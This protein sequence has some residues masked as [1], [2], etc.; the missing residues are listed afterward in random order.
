MI[1]DWKKSVRDKTDIKLKRK[2]FNWTKMFPF[3]KNLFTHHLWQHNNVQPLF[4]FHPQQ[5]Q[6]V[7]VLWLLWS[8]EILNHTFIT[9]IYNAE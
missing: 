8:E 1:Y 5:L 9:T 4:K 3:Q 2:N 7:T 6:I